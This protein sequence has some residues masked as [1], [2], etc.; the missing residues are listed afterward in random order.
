MKWDH[1]ST[2][3]GVW[4]II[5]INKYLLALSCILRTH[6]WST[7][8]SVVELKA[9]HSHRFTKPTYPTAAQENGWFMTWINTYMNMYIYSQVLFQILLLPCYN[10]EASVLPHHKWKIPMKK[11]FLAQ[12]NCSIYT[13]Y[14]SYF[15]Y[16]PWPMTT[17]NPEYC[18]NTPQGKQ[19]THKHHH[20][21]R[22][23]EWVSGGRN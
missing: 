13:S 23:T 19:M 17:P 6:K 5:S 18:P 21:P 2:W 14:I 4:H 7:L 22:D 8:I 20:N 15:Y 9:I 11:K 1:E 16:E 3:H 12:N 10:C